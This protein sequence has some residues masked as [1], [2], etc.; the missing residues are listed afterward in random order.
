MA[1]DD[2]DFDRRP[3]P[4]ALLVLSDKESRGKLCV[5]LGAAPG[6]G[7]TYAMLARAQAAK[8]EGVDVVI[9]VAETHGRLETQALV[10]GLETLPRRKCDYRGRIIEEFDIDAAL[11]RK[12]QLILVDELAHTNAP[13]SRHPKRWQDVEEL[14]DVGIDVW[15]TLNV[16]HLESLA[17]VV[18]RVTGVAVRETVPDRVLQNAT[19]VILVDITPDELLQRLKEGK[20]YVPETAKR[21]IQNFFTPRNLTALRELA[22]RRTAERVDDQMVDFLRQGAI[23]GPWATAERLLV[24]VGRDA[25]SEA[26][27]RAGARLATALNAT[28]IALYVE[29]AGQEEQSAEVV[30]NVD[31]SLRLAERLGAEIARVTGDDLVGEALRFARRENITQIVLGRSPARPFPQYLRRSLTDEILRR[32]TDIAVHVVVQEDRALETRRRPKL[33]TL[34][35]AWLGVGGAV[36]AVAITVFIGYAL[37]RWLGLAN[38]SV[39]FLLPV[40][41]CAAR[42]GMWSAIVAAVLSFLACDFFFF[43]PRYQLTIS[44]PQEFLSL[45]VALI[46]AVITGMLASKMRDYAQNMRQRSQAV[47][48]LFEFSRKLSTITTLDDILWVSA[49]QIQKAGE[50]S[51]VVMLMPEDVGL[52]VAAAWPPVDE[53]DAGELAAARWALEKNEPAGWRT[54]TL[55]NV[56]FQFRPL[57]T[58]RGVVAVCGIEPKTPDEPL[59]AA[60]ESTI[61]SLIEQTAIAIDR[62]MLV[63]ESVK[64][65]ALEENEK[66]RTIL[67]SALSH[68]LRTPLTSI[69]GAVTSLRELGEKLSPEDRKDL[70]LS[71]EEEAGRLS[72]FIANMLDMSR[73]ESGAI[74]PVSDL[75]N[76][77][78]VIRNVLER[79]KKTFHGKDTSISIAPNLPLIRGDANLLGQVLFNLIDN[80]HKY[81]GPT[82]AII[83]ARREGADVVITVTDEGPGVKT[84]DLERIFE[85]FYRSGR[86]DGRKA[87]TGLGLS[88]CRGLVKAM[89]GAIVAQSPAVR[90]RGTRIIM[91]FPAAS[92]S[93]HGVAA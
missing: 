63:G 84:A 66:L 33:P 29:H 89:G 61:S 77:A 10:N 5:F 4:D 14:L 76:V 65:A 78:E 73:I 37:D 38:P 74:S 70:L 51:C 81:G 17:D 44:E 55:P 93:K 1:R 85:K 27:V 11:T 68:D 32:S 83:H 9:G 60:S 58:A 35:Q 7:K 50:A 19:D 64:A 40:V 49:L 71:I 39:I 47:Q 45:L 52:R 62:S 16:Q 43:E 56:R 72:R 88:I 53:M 22:L 57:A 90:R 6:V 46:V 28:W 80:A 36:L 30:K 8:A 59:S 54:D 25:K 67:L 42:F 12:P 24:C 18:S 91:R 3:D 41:L 15:T 75:V 31:Q 23:E 2:G 21:A 69:T 20:V 92:E 87:G 82:G 79:S 13:D 48:S 34:S 26:V 86:V